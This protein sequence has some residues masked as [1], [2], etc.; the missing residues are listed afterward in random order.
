LKKSS[1]RVG[2]VGVGVVGSACKFGFEKLGHKVSIHDPKHG[3]QLSNVVDTDIVFLCVPTPPLEDGTCDISI[4]EQTIENLHR[5]NYT[6]VVAVKSTVTPGTTLKL[7]EKYKDMRMC[8]VPEFLRERCALSDFVENHTLLAVGCT[9]DEDYETVVS[10]HGNYP[11]RTVKMG[12]SE[13]EML[14]YYSNIFNALRIIFANEIFELCSAIGVSYEQVKSAYIMTEAVPDRYLDVNDNFRGYGGICLPK[15]VKAIAKLI[16]SHG[17]EHELI[18]TI[19]KENAKYKTTVFD[20]M[21][22]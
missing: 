7:Q 17:L 19:D 13:A 2:V 15:D 18:K 14:K 10:V 9:R 5:M 3:T 21:R 4:V 1:Y 11:R 20:G 8:F 16:E 6:G 22:L 12:V